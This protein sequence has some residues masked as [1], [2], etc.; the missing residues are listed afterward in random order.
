MEVRAEMTGVVASSALLYNSPITTAA[1]HTVSEICD[2]LS[3]TPNVTPLTRRYVDLAQG[4]AG[5]ALLF[6]YARQL[7]CEREID[8]F[9]NR[10]ISGLGKVPLESSLFQ[11]VAGILWTIHHLRSRLALP[12][13]EDATQEIDEALLSSVSQGHPTACY[14][15]IS[16]TV[17]VAV[18]AL[19]RLPSAWSYECLTSIL[20]RLEQTALS[21]GEGGLTWKTDVRWVPIT[22]REFAA[23]G[24]FNL[25]VAHGVPGV[26]GVLASMLRCGVEPHRVTP[27]LR[28][29]VRWL[30]R[31]RDPDRVAAQ[32]GYWTTGTFTK[33]GTGIAWCY[34]D[35]GIALV[36]L[37]AAEA[38]ASHSADWKPIAIQLADG[39]LNWSPDIYQQK[40]GCLCHG[41]AG[42]GHLFHRLYTMTGL[43]R[44]RRAA[45]VW[46][47]HT[48][49]LRST[50]A[51]NLCYI[52][53][54]GKTGGSEV[55]PGL[56]D[57][58]AGVALALQAAI[59]PE[60]PH[61][62]RPFLLS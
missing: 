52:F 5:I 11:G 35:L 17:G 58:S 45:I 27:L 22:D 8:H 44:F 50:E 2:G 9:L 16:G 38:D 31:H 49:A 24:Y 37:R 25:G 62:N 6:A 39:F 60:E 29:S 41:A 42:A 15:L 32:Y 30:L 55:R 53:P 46:F 1:L 47:S 57:G 3:A 19:E 20:D 59:D 12:I 4:A 21:D 40:D 10:A 43:E 26:I 14:D 48:L 7:S 23:D 28:G 54:N 13:D 18:Y 33:K 61:W 36:L 34:G 56:L 51:G